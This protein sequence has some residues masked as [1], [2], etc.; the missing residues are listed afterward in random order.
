MRSR[1][2]VG[3]AGDDH[4]A[5][6]VADEHDVAQVLELEHAEHVLDVR[7]EVDAGRARCARSPRPVRWA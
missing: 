2:A 5:V 4:A 7:L 6:A 3:D 1:R